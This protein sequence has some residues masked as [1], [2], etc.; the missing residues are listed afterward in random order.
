MYFHAYRSGK[1][2]RT[3]F[4][5]IQEGMLFNLLYRRPD[6]PLVLVNTKFSVIKKFFNT[7]ESKAYLENCWHNSESVK[8]RDIDKE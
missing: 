4:P 1:I 5:I 3:Y 6:D 8:H 2:V 7:E